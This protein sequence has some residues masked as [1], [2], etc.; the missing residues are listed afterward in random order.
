MRS[1]LFLIETIYRDQFGRNYLKNK[2]LFLNFFLNFRN[3]HEILNI[4]KKKDDRDSWFFSEITHSGKRGKIYIQKV[5]F[6][7]TLWQA[8]W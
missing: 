4:F 2:K 1:I 7:T 6:R 3:L 5:P 8:T